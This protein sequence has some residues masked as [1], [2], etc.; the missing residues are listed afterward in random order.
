MTRF[1]TAMSSNDYP[2]LG[3]CSSNKYRLIL[4]KYDKSYI[5][6]RYRSPKWRSLKYFVDYESATTYINND[7]SLSFNVIYPYY[8][9]DEDV[10]DTFYWWRIPRSQRDKKAIP[11]FLKNCDQETYR[12]N[13]IYKLRDL[14]I[15]VTGVVYH[16]DHMWPI[17]D[18]GPHWSG[19][20]Q[21]IPA[22]ENLIKGAT[23][24]PAIKAT[25]QEMLAEEERLHAEH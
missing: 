7:N 25:I 8:L 21:I 17:S 16:V 5:L 20:L 23:V 6:Q 18:G 12:I 2:Y 10:Y 4:D 9:N 15:K 14:M 24:D 13:K 3:L 1:N 11:E 22:E 19:N